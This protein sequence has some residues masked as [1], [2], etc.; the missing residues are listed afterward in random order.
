[1]TVLYLVVLGAIGIVV[2]HRYKDTRSSG[3]L[4]LGAAL[5]LWPLLTWIPNYFLRTQIDLMSNGQPNFPF[6]L[7]EGR[8]TLGEILALLSVGARLIQMSLVLVGF[9]LLSRGK[10]F[11]RLT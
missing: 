7:L 6:S 4:V 2:V 1:M 9:L 11:G 10:P 3:Y 5:V 8:M